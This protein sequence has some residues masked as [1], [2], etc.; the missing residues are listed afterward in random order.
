MKSDKDLDRKS[1]KHF[2]GIAHYCL[3]YFLRKLYSE[4]KSYSNISAPSD[5]ELL[6]SMATRLSQTEQ[7]L[8]VCTREVIEKV[9]NNYLRQEVM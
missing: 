3:N 5:M 4:V 1:K 9:V 7:Q 6:S 8:R 2:P